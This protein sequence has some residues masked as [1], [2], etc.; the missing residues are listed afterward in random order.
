MNLNVPQAGPIPPTDGIG[1]SSAASLPPALQSQKGEAGGLAFLEIHES[2]LAAAAGAAAFSS[3]SFTN[4]A[5]LPTRL[6]R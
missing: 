4:V 6:R 3:F 2:Y 1:G 5:P